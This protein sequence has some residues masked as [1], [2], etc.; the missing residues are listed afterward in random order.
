[1]VTIRSFLQMEGCE[2]VKNDVLKSI[3]DVVIKGIRVQDEFTYNL[4]SMEIN[5]IEKKVIV[6]GLTEDIAP[7]A[8][9]LDD[10]IEKLTKYQEHK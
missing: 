4:Y 6:Y 3:G 9:D 8:I 10:F 7:L 2:R 5:Y 1:M